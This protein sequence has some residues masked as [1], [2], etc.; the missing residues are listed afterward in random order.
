MANVEELEELYKKFPKH[1]D[2]LKEAQKKG[3]KKSTATSWFYKIKQGYKGDLEP[4]NETVERVPTVDIKAPLPTVENRELPEARELAD[5]Y[6]NM[7]PE[8]S[9]PD[10]TSGAEQPQQG[11]QPPPSSEGGQAGSPFGGEGNMRIQL[12]KMLETIGVTIDNMIWKERQLTEDEK[13]QI[14]TYSSDIE[15]EF[16]TTLDS[17][18]SPYINYALATI[19]VPAIARIDLLPLKFYQMQNAFKGTRPSYSSAAE[20]PQSKVEQ[21]QERNTQQAQAAQVDREKFGMT[22]EDINS[23]GFSDNVKQWLSNEIS[24]GKRVS[25]RYD[26]MKGFDRDAYRNGIVRN[27][28]DPFGS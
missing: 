5:A 14:A 20:V 22:A 27:I 9:T 3:Y 4:A 23:S 17:E 28:G 8:G 13:A 2:F 7:I 11:E 21:V 15:T 19:V 18:Y 26:N 6:K 12:G 16:G 1:S 10:I 24:V 25:P